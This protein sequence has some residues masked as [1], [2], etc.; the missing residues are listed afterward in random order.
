MNY[1]LTI[2]GCFLGT[3]IGNALWYWVIK[4]YYDRHNYEGVNNQ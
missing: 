4:P 2:L 1:L 3:L